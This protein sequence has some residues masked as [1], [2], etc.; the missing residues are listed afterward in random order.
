MCV[1]PSFEPGIYNAWLFMII[2]PLQWIAVL[3]LPARIR[4]RT[5]HPDECKTGPGAGAIGWLTQIVW[6]GA[7]LYSIFLPLKVGTSWFYAGL[8]AFV[9]GMIILVWAT[10]IVVRTAADKTF[11]TGIYSVSR[12]PMYLSMILVY[13][14]VSIASAS[15]LF[16]LITIATFFLQRLQMIQE[17]QYC[18][19]K[20]GG[21]YIEYME[22]TPRWIGVPKAKSRQLP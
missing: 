16:L 5:G 9:I 2:Y 8:G 13:L 20:F 22:R 1:I 6:V 7:T 21:S 3:F 17:E 15:W 12:H 4:D 14:G 10:L 18:C 11:V 19:R